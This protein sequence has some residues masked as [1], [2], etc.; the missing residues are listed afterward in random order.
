MCLSCFSFSF[1][2]CSSSCFLSCFS[3]CFPCS[4]P[5]PAAHCVTFHVWLCFTLPLRSLLLLS[6][7]SALAINVCDSPAMLHATIICAVRRRRQPGSRSHDQIQPD[8]APHLMLPLALHLQPQNNELGLRCSYCQLPVRSCLFPVPSCLFAAVAAAFAV[9]PI[10]ADRFSIDRQ[11]H[12]TAHS[13]D[14]SLGPIPPSRW[15]ESLILILI[16][17]CIR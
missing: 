5:L 11:H 1:S 17:S 7:S 13:L 10:C 6:C 15:N 12:A 9:A 2:S 14:L 8:H 4:L 16:L 3:S